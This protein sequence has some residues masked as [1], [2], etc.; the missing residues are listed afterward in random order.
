MNIQ[1]IAE[2]SVDLDLLS[3]GICIDAGCLGFQFSEAMRD[4]GLEVWAY[5]I[6]PLVAPKGIYFQQAAI[7]V[8]DGVYYY[9]DTKDPQAKYISDKGISVCGIELNWIMREHQRD[10]KDIDILKMDI[11][12]SEYKILSNP[13]FAPI[14]KQISVEFH[15][16]AHKSLHDKYFS[17]CIANLERHYVAVK[18]DRY[19][20]HGCGMN[21]WDSLFLR[22]DL[23]K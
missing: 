22:R 8:D 6:Q 14:P 21:W 1:Y 16:H 5:D 23:I 7:M 12:G 10:G 17:A 2:H 11:E 4:K 18:H 3:G 9:T 20:A 13:L 19:E 15:E